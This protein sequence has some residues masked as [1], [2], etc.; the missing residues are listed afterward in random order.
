MEADYRTI[1]VAV[2]ES[3]QSM[4]ALTWCLHNLPAQHK[5]CT[6]VLL[7]VK[8]PPPVYSSLDPAGQLKASSWSTF[9]L[10][11]ARMNHIDS[12]RTVNNW[13]CFYLICFTG[14]LFG[15]DDV[16]ANWEKYAKNLAASV[17]RKAEAIC[18]N[19]DPKVLAFSP[20]FPFVFC[21][22]FFFSLSLPQ[23]LTLRNQTD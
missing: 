9:T 1:L 12:S 14:Y 16:I 11:Y 23:L 21:F 13:V 5:N 6:L 3:E 19:F 10:E 17:M 20:S 15:H 4:Y 2:D 22:I 8:P 7:Y 18:Q